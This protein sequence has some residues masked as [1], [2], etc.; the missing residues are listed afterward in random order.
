[1][2]ELRLTDNEI[3]DIM[4][5][6][7]RNS[8]SLQLNKKKVFYDNNG[9]IVIV[10]KKRVPKYNWGFKIHYSTTVRNERRNKSKLFIFSERTINN[11]DKQFEYYNPYDS[12]YEDH[13]VRFT[14]N[15]NTKIKFV[16]V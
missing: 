15:E 12:E 7:K 3:L 16:K 1:M 13:E 6:I 5:L 10:V 4:R 11:V 9:F 2:E 14:W 8:E